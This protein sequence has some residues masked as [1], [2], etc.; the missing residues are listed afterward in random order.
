MSLSR[1]INIQGQNG[2]RFYRG[3]QGVAWQVPVNLKCGSTLFLSAGCREGQYGSNS[4][5]FEIA[6][7][8]HADEF[9]SGINLQEFDLVEGFVEL[10]ELAKIIVYLQGKTLVEIDEIIGKAGHLPIRKEAGLED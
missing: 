5:C 8:R 2:Y 10:T 4:G 1:E 7:F 9:N 6:L 3:T